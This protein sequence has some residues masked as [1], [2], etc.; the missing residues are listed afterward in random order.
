MSKVLVLDATYEDCA[1]AIEEVFEAFPLDVK[2]K[3]VIVKVNA[4]KVGDP[5]QCVQ[6][7]L[8]DRSAYPDA[9]RRLDEH[10]SMRRL[11]VA[12]PVVRPIEAPC[13]CRRCGGV[14]EKAGV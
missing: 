3:T 9:A 6:R 13:R 7:G 2:G 11:P 10:P 1:H 14:S 12:G 4:L 5:V 8:R